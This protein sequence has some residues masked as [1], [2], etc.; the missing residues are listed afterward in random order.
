MGLQVDFEHKSYKRLGAACGLS[1]G[2]DF[3][4]FPMYGRRRRCNAYDDGTITAF[5]GEASYAEDGSNG[6]VMIYQPKFFYKT[7]ILKMEKKTNGD[8]YNI[9]KANYYISSIACKGFKLHPAFRDERGNAVDYILLSAY[10][11]SLYQASLDRIFNDGIDNNSRLDFVNDKICSVAYAK[12][13]TGKYKPLTITAFEK[14]C[15]ARG[16]GWH[17]D[18]IKSIS[19]NQILMMIE[20]GTLDFQSC[21]GM[22]VVAL[23]NYSSSYYNCSAITGST[24]P[25]GNGTGE[26]AET[27]IEING[28]RIVYRSSGYR[29]IS[30]R[31]MENVWGNIWKFSQGANIWGNGGT[32][33]SKIFIAN[34]FDFDNAK[35]TGN[36]QY[37]GFAGPDA[38]GYIKNFGYGSDKYDWLLLTSDVANSYSSL[39]C[40]FTYSKSNPN[41]NNLLMYGGRWYNNE[42]NGGFYWDLT[43][44]KDRYIHWLGG[45]MIYIPTKGG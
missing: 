1:M 35:I 2:A 13:I 15:S 5:Y 33:G 29:S 21:I 6:Q 43:E 7:E 38:S 40:D 37:T 26:A 22:G 9:Q 16:R 36:Y 32:G 31:G 8:G 30:Y 42:K 34:D 39:N 10:E 12:P 27:T 14:L 23:N 18:T 24:S 17:C 11:G 44:V 3:D 20:L 25:L 41:G 19:A 45:R 28:N 4:K